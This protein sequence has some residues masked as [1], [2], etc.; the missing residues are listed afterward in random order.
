MERGLL[1][2][3]YGT[4][5]NNLKRTSHRTDIVK[6]INFSSSSNQKKNNIKSRLT[7]SDMDEKISCLNMG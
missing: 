1:F 2:L 5:E 7:A 6:A 3:Q 4:N